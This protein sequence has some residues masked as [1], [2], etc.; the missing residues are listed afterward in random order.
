MDFTQIK[1]K[2]IKQQPGD[3]LKR[4]ALISKSGP[5]L[6]KLSLAYSYV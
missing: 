2:K 6:S 3:M 1:K 4:H 5:V